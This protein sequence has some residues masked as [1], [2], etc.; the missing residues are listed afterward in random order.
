MGAFA[1]PFRVLAKKICPEI[2]CYVELVP[3]RGEKHFK[4]HP[5]NRI[6]VPL[7]SVFKTLLATNHRSSAAYL[8]TLYIS[9]VT[10]TSVISL[11]QTSLALC[12]IKKSLGRQN[13]YFR[14]KICAWHWR[15]LTLE[16]TLMKTSKTSRPNNF[17]LHQFFKSQP[18]DGFVTV[19]SSVRAMPAKKH[20]ERTL[21]VTTWGICKHPGCQ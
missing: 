10:L 21:R 5:Q 17:S 1:V 3:I 15:L 20:N 11:R 19:H 18:S 2:M 8:I 4:Q 14:I 16:T 7:R 12:L 6:L 13:N 9:Q